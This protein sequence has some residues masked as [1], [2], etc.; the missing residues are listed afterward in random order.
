MS[1]I[2]KKIEWLVIIYD[3]QPV[4]LR[5]TF[6]AEHLSKIPEKIQAG[7]ITSCGPIFEDE[8]KERFLGSSFTILAESKPEVL[9][10]LRSDIYSQQGVWDFDN[11]V[12]HPYAPAYR[13][14]QELPK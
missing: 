4:N 3:K 6:R 2:A 5:L 13:S 1:R 7:N 14:G 10:I 11:V 9:S 12:I 8:T